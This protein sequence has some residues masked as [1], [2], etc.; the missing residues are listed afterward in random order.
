MEYAPPP[1]FRQ[2]P[3]ALARLAAFA[4]LSVLLLVL[5]TR[6]KLLERGRLAVATVLY[7]LQRAAHAPGDAE[8]GRAHV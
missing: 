5:D 7:P 8:I 4:L 2:G 3:S 1:F 6:F